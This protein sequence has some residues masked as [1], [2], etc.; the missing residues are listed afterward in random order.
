MCCR[1]LPPP[2]IKRDVETEILGGQLCMRQMVPDRLKPLLKPLVAP[3]LKRL[4]NSKPDLSIDVSSFDGFNNPA[5]R[6]VATTRFYRQRDHQLI[7]GWLS[8]KE[9]QVLYALAR[10]LP[11]PIIE[12]GS[13][14]GLSTVAIAQG[15]RDSRQQKKFIAYD[16]GLTKDNFRMVDGGV[17]RFASGDIEPLHVCSLET[18]NHDVLP[19]LSLP[20][21]Q[22]GKLQDNLRSFGVSDLVEVIVED[23]KKVIPPKASLVFCDTLHKDHEIEVN[24]PHL[25]KFLH[26]GSILACHDIG[27]HRDQVNTLRSIVGGGYSTIVD[28]LFIVEMK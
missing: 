27:R 8:V 20:G 17:G 11:G 15:I 3:I 18:F 26:K 22:L 19:I 6:R 10:W 24:A 13:W 5:M 1:L 25:S 23:F 21:G 9:R 12:I 7:G 14:I 28:S 16:C 2:S 4:R